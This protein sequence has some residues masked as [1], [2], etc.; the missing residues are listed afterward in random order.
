MKFPDVTAHDKVLSARLLNCLVVHSPVERLQSPCFHGFLSRVLLR[1]NTTW[2]PLNHRITGSAP[3][4]WESWHGIEHRIARGKDDNPS[5]S[6]IYRFT[7]INTSCLKHDEKRG[8]TVHV[9]NMMKIT[10]DS[11]L[12]LIFQG[13]I[14][15]FCGL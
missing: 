6:N 7:R 8:R 12:R 11:S 10:V 5:H 1:R 2:F 14:L 15:I 13:Q 3:K 9:L 4:I